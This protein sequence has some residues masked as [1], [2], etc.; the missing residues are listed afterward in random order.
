M[1]FLSGSYIRVAKRG[2]V[3]E[4]RGHYWPKGLALLA[5]V[6][7]LAGF[8]VFMSRMEKGPSGQPT[9]GQLRWMMLIIAA[10]F[11]LVVNFGVFASWRLRIDAGAGELELSRRWGIFKSNRIARQKDQMPLFEPFKSY[12]RYPGPSLHLHTVDVFFPVYSTWTWLPIAYASFRRDNARLFA[13]VANAMVGEEM[14]FEADSVPGVSPQAQAA[15]SA[16][17]VERFLVSEDAPREEVAKLRT[18][19]GLEFTRKY[20][21]REK[22]IAAYKQRPGADQVS[23]AVLLFGASGVI[24]PLRQMLFAAAHEGKAN[25]AREAAPLLEHQSEEVRRLALVALVVAAATP[26]SPE[27]DGLRRAAAESKDPVIRRQA[28]TALKWLANGRAA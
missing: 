14:L 13:D 6:L 12:A 4:S 22:V 25:L 24:D 20:L 2:K 5:F 9:D 26:E 3:L 21:A 27:A 15:V 7:A 19:D 17:E 1:S 16:E 18:R 10:V 28:S 23:E 8:V 11:L